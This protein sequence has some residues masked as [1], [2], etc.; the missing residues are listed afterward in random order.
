MS[1]RGDKANEPER[2]ALTPE[3]LDQEIKRR[4][5]VDREIDE[6]GT[7]YSDLPRRMVS[8]NQIVAY[9]MA[10]Y[11]K[12]AGMTQEE[13]GEELQG[14]TSK[15]WSKAAVSAAERSWDGKRT[16][17]FDADLLF[18]LAL[19]LGVPVSAFFLPPDTDGVKE[20][21]EAWPPHP[22]PGTLAWRTTMEELLGY[23]LSDPEDEEDTDEVSAMAAYR[24]RLS[25]AGEMYLGSGLPEDYF[26]D[27]TTEEQL[28][29]RASRLRQ[30]H[31]TLRGVIGDLDQSLDFIYSRISDLRQK[32]RE[33]PHGKQVFQEQQRRRLQR[34]NERYAQ[35]VK[36][37]RDLRRQGETPEAIADK[38][39]IPLGLVE[40]IIEGT[41]RGSQAE[42]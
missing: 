41:A 37:T 42:E 20:R 7:D 19:A 23:A 35:Q 26:E 8:L 2:A 25:S 9:N 11:R 31:E 33:T 4:E 5:E 34:M 6:A 10:Y 36:E 1:N 32:Q 40:R 3:E 13:L 16:R 15:P 38:V 27:I 12:A 28:I 24:Q 29:G 14:W 39:G 30:Q 21:V 18:G 22:H 17:Q